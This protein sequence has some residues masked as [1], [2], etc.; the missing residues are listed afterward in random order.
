MFFSL[1]SKHSSSQ[2]MQIGRPPDKIINTAKLQKENDPSKE[3]H[4]NP[5]ILKSVKVSVINNLNNDN[6][7]HPRLSVQVDISNNKKVVK[8]PKSPLKDRIVDIKR[9][10]PERT[11]NN[12][13]KT[14]DENETNNDKI[15]TDELINTSEVDQETVRED[16]SKPY[17]GIPMDLNDYKSPLDSLQSQM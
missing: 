2:D 4:K 9:I 16:T 1:P 8:M 7:V 17:N 6:V 12:V 15:K 10:S 13:E 5:A 3:E 14:N 11:N